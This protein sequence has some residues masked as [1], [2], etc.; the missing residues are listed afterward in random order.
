M[1]LAGITKNPTGAWTTQA[2]RS[3]CMGY[4][5][6]LIWNRSQLQKLLRG[7]VGQYNTHRPHRA[8]CGRTFVMGYLAGCFA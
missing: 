8:C 7:Y 1:H 6:T 2:A 5:R 4:D 3:F